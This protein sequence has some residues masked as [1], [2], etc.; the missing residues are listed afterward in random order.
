MERGIFSTSI[1]GWGFFSALFHYEFDSALN[2]F[3]IVFEKYLKV[4]NFYYFCSI[5]FQ[6]KVVKNEN[7]GFNDYSRLDSWKGVH[8]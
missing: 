4:K 5:I 7:I 6:K 2:L 8:K 1:E 3:S